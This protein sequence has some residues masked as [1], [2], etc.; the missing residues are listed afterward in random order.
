MYGYALL[1]LLCRS[2]HTRVS[3]HPVAAS[4]SVFL[5]LEGVC[6]RAAGPE[7]NYTSFQLPDTEL[8]Y[9]SAL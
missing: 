4:A 7:T 6:Q 5:I 3:S 8:N 1:L 2:A 9:I